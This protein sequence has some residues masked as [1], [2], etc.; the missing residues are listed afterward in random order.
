MVSM[1]VNKEA[2]MVHCKWRRL[3]K[4]TGKGDHGSMKPGFHSN[5]IACVEC[6][7]CVA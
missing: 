7:A 5:T 1:H 2:T 4:R 6:V 3:I